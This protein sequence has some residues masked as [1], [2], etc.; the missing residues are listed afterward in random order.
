M[1]DGYVVLQVLL[2]AAAEGQG[3][4]R[5]QAITLAREAM[6]RHK[7]DEPT[8]ASALEILEEVRQRAGGAARLK[9]GLGPPDPGEALRP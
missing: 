3:A 4:S 9:R 8:L 7:Y 6:E 5:E 1:A 2:V